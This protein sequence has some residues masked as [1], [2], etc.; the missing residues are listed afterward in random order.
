[1]E[2]NIKTHFVKHLKRFVNINFEKPNQTKEDKQQMYK[3]AKNIVDDLINNTDK[4]ELY[5]KGKSK[6]L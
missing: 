1:L 6:Y 2:T 4:F 3:N 5:Q